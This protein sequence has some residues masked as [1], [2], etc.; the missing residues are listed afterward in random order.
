MPSP[1][2]NLPPDRRGA[3]HRLHVHADCLVGNP[4]GDPADREILVYTP[5]GYEAGGAFP[6]ILVLPGFAGTGEDALGRSMLDPS[7][8]TRIDQLIAAGCPPF[9]AVLPDVMTSIG[10][11]QYLDS[12]G[13]GRYQTFLADVV[14]PAVDAAFRT[15]GRWGATGRSSGAFGAFHLAV[16]APATFRA[17]AWHAGDA[18]F[19]LCYLEDIPKAIRGV[20]AAGGVGPFLDSFWG[21]RRVGGDDFAALNVLAMCCAYS[22]D[23]S[24][25]PLPAHLCFDPVTGA[26]DFDVLRSWQV[27]D[28]VVVARDPA[29]QAALRSLDLLYLDAGAHDEYLLHLGARRLVAELTRG[30]VPHIYDEFPGGH[31][32]TAWRYELSLPK[33]ARALTG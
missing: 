22:P 26:V 24:R 23:P 17:I 4:W 9:L 12:P 14:R 33:L 31:R 10:G 30:G 5:P 18:G 28:P 8:P 21:R 2:P 11:S 1:F 3:V 27:H 6:A 19:D 20:L 15:T 13:I 32:G 16:R 29:A 7:L 25:R